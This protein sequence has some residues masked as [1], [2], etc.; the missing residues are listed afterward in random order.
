MSKLSTVQGFK[1]F[2]IT[3]EGKLF[4]DANGGN[5]RFYFNL[6]NSYFCND[7]KEVRC[8]GYGYHFCERLTDVFNYYPFLESMAYC[9]V[10]GLFDIKKGSYDI[11]IGKDKI[12]TRGIRIVKRLTWDEVLEQIKRENSGEENYCSEWIDNSYFCINSYVVKESSYINK[13]KLIE[14]SSNISDS[15]LINNSCNIYHSNNIENSDTISISNNVFQCSLIADSNN[16]NNSEL[17]L[18]S[19]NIS[20][21]KNII[22]SNLCENS[23]YIYNSKN[24]T[25]CF[26]VCKAG[27]IINSDYIVSCEN[28][29]DCFFCYDLT[30]N[31]L[32]VFNK[33]VDF[34]RV[35]AVKNRFTELLNSLKY[36]IDFIENCGFQKLKAVNSYTLFDFRYNDRSVH[37]IKMPQEA[38]DYLKSL[39]EFDAEIFEKITNI[40][41]VIHHVY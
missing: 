14:D 18:S 7:I 24:I 27:N 10:E 12:A 34:D 23:N 6:G 41:E 17:V 19:N 15:S 1:A 21:C 28:I 39:P 35:C 30:D 8:C 40:K 22:K 26:Y 9:Q 29:R 20:Y 37:L 25:N 16:I 36:Q 38:I 32:C 11:D 5:E 33:K 4:T 31:R 2:K 13:S 3:Q